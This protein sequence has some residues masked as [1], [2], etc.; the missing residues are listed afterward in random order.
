MDWYALF[1]TTG[2]EEYVI[3]WLDFFLHGYKFTTIIPKRKL[4]ERKAGK[5]NLVY[6]K[7]FPGYILLNTDMNTDVYHICNKVPGLIRILNSGEYYTRIPHEEM[8]CIQGLLGEGEIIDI[9]KIYIKDSKVVVKSGPLQG[10]EGLIK[11]IDLRKQRV[12]I[13]IQ[14]MGFIREVDIGIEI[15]S[16]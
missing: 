1:V 8:D 5:V 4:F 16:L 11:A 3:D 13:A 2:K 12:R 6:K 9:S 10:R 14:F 15:L 7:M